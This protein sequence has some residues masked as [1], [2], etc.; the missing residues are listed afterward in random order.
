MRPPASTRRALLGGAAAGAAAG[1]AAPALWLNPPARGQ[2]P[3]DR[4]GVAAI[5]LGGQG[6]WMSRQA[7]R[8]GN[9]VACCDIR[10]AQAER[11]AASLGKP[12]EIYTD[13]RKV[14]ERKDVDVINCATPDFWHVKIAVDA[15]KA[16]K[17][18]YCEKPLTLTIDEG[19]LICEAVKKYGRVLQV[20][21]QQRSEARQMFL[22]AVALARGGR[23]GKKL[24]ARVQTGEAPTGG[25]FEVGE[26]PKDLDW[27][28]YLGQTRLV[29]YCK[30]RIGFTFRWW[31]EY[32]GGQ[33]TDWG[34]HHMD[35]ALWA[36]GGESTGVVEVEGKG[37]FP[38][39]VWKDVKPVDV[40][41]G[42]AALPPAYNVTPTYACE[43]K[44]PNGNTILF[45][46]GKA[47][48]VT[49]E[50]EG[51][52]VVVSREKLTGAPV[53]AAEGSESDRAWLAGEVAKLYRGMRIGAQRMGGHMQNFFDCVK[54]RQL[55]ISDAFTHV[56]TAN[57]C[58][59]ANLAMLLGRK[60]T[61][62]PAAG[63]FVGD[64]EANALRRREPRKGY[65][66]VV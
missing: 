12:C 48:T 33:V 20:G 56:H 8:L 50:G 66:I 23:L 9:M 22:K 47:Y 44:L 60:L 29:P 7:S 27:D 5:G 36:L 10:R 18:V 35:I 51:G 24:K 37:A 45:D 26:A 43:F 1:F 39:E 49:I 63:A 4:L 32:S 31:L 42:R 19:R 14:L 3:N 54:S 62:D 25:P 58:H 40:L 61:W 41:A 64:D 21:T 16:G 6:S 15:M 38:K 57:A 28:F 53:E 65:E 2:S 13:Y 17:D 34:A 59:M 11:F 30:E 55:P 52:Q 46:S